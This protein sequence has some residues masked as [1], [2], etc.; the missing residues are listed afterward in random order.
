MQEKI[1][2]QRKFLTVAE[3]SNYL[4]VKEKTIYA[5]VEVGD[6]PCYRIGKLIRFNK[7][8]IDAWLDTKKVIKVD[9]NIAAQNILRSIRKPSIDIQKVV[10]KTI[11]EAKGGGYTLTNG[12]SDRIGT[13]GKENN[14]GSI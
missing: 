4:S 5:R 2:E 6:L 14:H 8:E 13:L 11:D 1:G 9:P 3:V 12:K 7:E 10:R